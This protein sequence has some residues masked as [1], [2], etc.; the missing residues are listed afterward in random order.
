M[1]KALRPSISASIDPPVLAHPRSIINAPASSSPGGVG[2]RSRIWG[3]PAIP[4]WA[5]RSLRRS[6][7]PSRNRS[8]T[9]GAIC[10]SSGHKPPDQDI[11]TCRDSPN[12]CGFSF[13]FQVQLPDNFGGHAHRRRDAD[14][15]MKPGRSLITIIKRSPPLFEF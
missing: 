7:W 15:P 12:S 14:E 8:I 4:R 3:T 1:Q 9:N 13:Q 10:N 6:A 11:Q 2:L 5:A